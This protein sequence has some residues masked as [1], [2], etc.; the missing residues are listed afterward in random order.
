[1]TEEELKQ[2]DDED[3][4]E[5]Q[6]IQ[7]MPY[8]ERQGLVDYHGISMEK[9]KDK[10]IKILENRIDE[11]DIEI[12]PQ[13]LIYLPQIK[14]RRIL[15]KA[16]GPGAWAIRPRTMKVKDETV[17]FEGEL[18]VEGRFIAWSIGEQQ[19]IEN[20]PIMSYA[21]ALEAAKSDCVT[22]LCKD[23]GIASELWD[24]RFIREWKKKY[25]IQVWI[26]DKRKPQ[27]RRKDGE[28]FYNETGIVKPKSENGSDAKQHS[29]E[30]QEVLSQMDRERNAKKDERNEKFKAYLDYCSKKKSEII[31]RDG[32]DKIYYD[33]LKAFKLDHANDVKPSDTDLM[34]NVMEALKGWKPSKKDS[35]KKPGEQG[36]FY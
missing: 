14:Y 9:F 36:K 21:T 3:I 23:L 4:E 10:Q 12:D 35:D 31:D 33:V 15:N 34:H 24:P 26:K 16:F 2:K 17:M 18:W 1:M 32:S 28:P 7:L 20:N 13:G 5:V 29:Q 22:R 6:D 27:W 30:N 8:K 25:A 11:D 19:Y